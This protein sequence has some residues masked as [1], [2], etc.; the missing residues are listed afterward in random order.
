MIINKTF[1]ET[2]KIK[3]LAYVN[4]L[5]CE[6]IEYYPNSNFLNGQVYITGAY[7]SS[8]TDEVKLISENLSFEFEF[9]ESNFYVED[10]ECVK[11]DYQVL[12]GIGVLVSFE[13]K[14]ELD[15][16]T[17]LDLKVDTNEENLENFKENITSKIDE[18]LAEKLD[19][20]D[21]NLP[22]NDSWFRGIKDESNTI[23]VIYFSDEKEL[24]N[25]ASNNN[26]ALDHLFKSNK[27]LD[28]NNNK[29]VIIKNGK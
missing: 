25:I 4:D 3:D 8:K 11:F 13:I 26:I 27:H 1:N 10:I 20:V 28:F 29:R 16:S 19:I 12:E 21:D 7:H 2:I 17:K 5:G 15:M 22:Q 23:K 18:R 14:L 9:L 24:S 6:V